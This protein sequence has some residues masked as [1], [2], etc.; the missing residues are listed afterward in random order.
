[1]N[2]L[3]SP[4]HPAI[5]GLC[6]LMLLSS[7]DE[8]TREGFVRHTGDYVSDIMHEILPENPDL[9][10]Q[11]RPSSYQP[12]DKYTP[13]QAQPSPERPS[14]GRPSPERPERPNPELPS[15]TGSWGAELYER[16]QALLKPSTS[17]NASNENEII[18]LLKQSAHAGYA[19]AQRDLAGLYLEGGKGIEMNKKRAYNWF[20]KA[21]AQ[22]DQAARYYSADLLYKGEGVIQN[23][24]KALE[25]WRIAADEGLGEAQYQL[26]KILIRADRTRQEGMDY[27]HRAARGGVVAAARDLGYVNAKGILGIDPDMRRAAH[28]YDLAARGGDPESLY[29]SAILLIDGQHVRQDN[30]KAIKYLEL[31]AGQDHVDAMKQL[32][33]SL[34]MR[35]TRRDLRAARSWESRLRELESKK[36]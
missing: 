4:R 34:E 21:A 20:Q 33:R 30:D 2:H 7:C 3:L 13:E 1:M 17:G 35:G 27:L 8:E 36:R 29:I 24:K 18:K 23:K 10:T 5:G 9:A 25:E 31:A 16:A 15:Y 32:I 6:A 22:G 11:Q 12:G 28:W 14:S 26:S 19:Q